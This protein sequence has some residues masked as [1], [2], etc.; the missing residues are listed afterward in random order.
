M[1]LRGGDRR[2]HARAADPDTYELRLSPDR[3]WL[4][5]RH[6]DQYHVIPYRETGHELLVTAETRELPCHRLTEHG[7]YALAWAADGRSVHWAVGPELH[8]RETG[9]W[10][11]IERP[12][13]VKLTVD[14]DVPDG[15]VALVGGTVI[16]MRGEEVHR[17]GTVVVRGNRIVAVGQVA[18]PEDAT[19][20]DC[21]G[22]TVMPGLIDAHGHIDGGSENGLTPQKQAA[23]FA[24]L[25]FGVTTNFDPFPSELPSFESTEST[26]A[27]LTVGPVPAGSAPARP[28]T[29]VRRTSST[30]TA[31]SRPT[32]TPRA[33]W[34]GRRPWAR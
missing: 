34:G 32:R 19:V 25:A 18:V 7:G 16:T 17:Q 27:G 26:Q 24:A 14:A 10:S 2:V 4:A 21:S 31:R 11:L 30:S 12:S 13:P 9:D 20:I 22:M 6:A 3:E 1:D 8:V 29:A 28:S 15:C 5:F 23:R 33:C